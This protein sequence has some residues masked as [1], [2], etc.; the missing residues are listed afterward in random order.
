MPRFGFELEFAANPGVREILN[1]NIPSGFIVGTDCTAGIGSM[2]G[3]ELRTTKE[4]KQGLP[5]EK[6]RTILEMIR[7]YDGMVHKTCGF[8]IHFSGF[9]IIDEL[10]VCD[11]VRSKKNLWWHSRNKWCNRSDSDFKYK[12]IRKVGGFIY[13][14]TGYDHYEI[15]CFN[16]TLNLRGICQMYKIARQAIKEGL[17][18]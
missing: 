9:G 14:P 17:I 4:F 8:H 12:I 5:R 11:F 2:Q 15:R 13:T 6:F 3:L 18:R 10:R 7:I 16:A 1:R